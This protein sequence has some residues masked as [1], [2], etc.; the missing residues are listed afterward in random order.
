M[1]QNRKNL[2]AWLRKV[3]NTTE[4]DFFTHN[5][6]IPVD[7]ST[8]ALTDETFRIIHNSDTTGVRTINLHKLRT[9]CFTVEAGWNFAQLLRTGKL[10]EE[11]GLKPGEQFV[12]LRT[13]QELVKLENQILFPIE[14]MEFP[15]FAIGTI[16]EREEMIHLPLITIDLTPEPPLP[17]IIYPG[18][19]KLMEQ[20]YK[21]P[22]DWDWAEAI[23][24]AMDEYD[25]EHLKWYDKLGY[26]LDI[27]SVAEY[28][29]WEDYLDHAQQKVLIMSA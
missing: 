24:E 9:E 7:Y 3:H 27:V 22:P 6:I 14:L 13:A 2:A 10:A 19:R 23:A 5:R 1:L 26:N 20:I 12:D 25:K 8:P 15:M 29:F 16:L 28:G 21:Y 11:F 18:N 4:T 17:D